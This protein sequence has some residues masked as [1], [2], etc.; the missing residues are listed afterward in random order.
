MAVERSC[1]TAYQDNDQDKESDPKL[2]LCRVLIVRDHDKIEPLIVHPKSADP[3]AKYLSEQ[4]EFYLEKQ[5]QFM[6]LVRNYEFD[7]TKAPKGKGEEVSEKLSNAK[8]LYYNYDNKYKKL[9]PSQQHFSLISI[10][11]DSEDKIIS[12]SAESFP[13]SEDQDWFRVFIGNPQAV[14]KHKNLPENL[15]NLIQQYFTERRRIQQSVS[16]SDELRMQIATINKDYFANFTDQD[17]EQTEDILTAITNTFGV[18]F[19]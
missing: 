3:R 16:D 5:D 13:E 2:N 18:G 15:K 12:W 4:I 11:R 1:L 7:L 10:N 9:S 19:N 14:E 17:W 6:V 8:E